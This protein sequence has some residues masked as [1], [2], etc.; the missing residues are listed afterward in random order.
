MVPAT[1]DKA[2]SLLV[3]H[4]AQ[5]AR[6]PHS[7]GR[8][9]SPLGGV[10]PAVPLVPPGSRR[11]ADEPADQRQLVLGH[12]AQGQ[13]LVRARPVVGR[14]G[15]RAQ[16]TPDRGGRSLAEILIIRVPRPPTGRSVH[17]PRRPGR[18]GC[19]CACL[20]HGLTVSRPRLRRPSSR[21]NRSG[22]RDLVECHLELCRG[23]GRGRVRR[24]ARRGCASTIRSC[25]IVDTTL[26]VKRP[27]GHG[28]ARGCS[29]RR[30]HT[31]RSD[32]GMSGRTPLGAA[33]ESVT[34]RVQPAN[35]LDA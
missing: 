34:H 15:G 2:Q 13:P 18:A 4:G 7:T 17:G 31:G 29:A 9:A 5:P 25:S 8:S 33:R 21:L 1:D 3:G 23:R 11:V 28:P 19:R 22:L 10:L 20:G 16:G 24:R 30:T 6:R 32:R 14:A 35:S 12:R 27:R 26:T